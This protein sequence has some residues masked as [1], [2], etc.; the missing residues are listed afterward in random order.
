MNETF[1]IGQS[2]LE[3]APDAATVGGKAANL[4][5]LHSVGLRVPP[6]IVLTTDVC[7]AYLETGALPSNFPTVLGDSIRRLEVVTGLRFGDPRHPLLLSVR[8]SPPISMPG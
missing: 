8:S 7:R 1:L 3:P 4:V 5:R 6:A 2:P